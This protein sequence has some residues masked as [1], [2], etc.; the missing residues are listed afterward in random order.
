MKSKKV[1]EKMLALMLLMTLLLSYFQ[2]FVSA[3][4]LLDSAS[5]TPIELVN[6]PDVLQAEVNYELG[7]EEILW[8]L[9]FDKTAIDHRRQLVMAIDIAAPTGQGTVEQIRGSNEEEFLFDALT[10]EWLLSDYD[11]TGVKELTFK[12]PYDPAV[13]GMMNVLFKFRVLEERVTTVAANEEVLAVAEIDETGADAEEVA[14]TTE[15]IMAVPTETI[16]VVELLKQEHELQIEIPELEI[17]E[18][19]PESPESTE[20]TDPIEIPNGEDTSADSGKAAAKAA[21]ASVQAAALPAAAPTS[22]GQVFP[23][24]I[25]DAV[26]LIIAP[27]AFSTLTVTSRA[28]ANGQANIYSKNG[29]QRGTI[30]TVTEAQTNVYSMFAP[31]STSQALVY[32]NLYNQINASPNGS[33]LTDGAGN[34]EVISIDYSIVGFVNIGTSAAPILKPIAARVT[35]ENII[36]G[37]STSNHQN[38]ECHPIIEISNNLYSGMFYE[39]VKKMDITFEFYDPST[40]EAIN[41]AAGTPTAADGALLTFASL[42]AYTNRTTYPATGTIQRHEFAGSITGVPGILSANSLLSGPRGT[43]SGVDDD[44]YWANKAVENEDF[45]DILG[46]ADFNRAAVSFPITGTLHK[47]KFGSTWGRAWNTFASSA[48]IPTMHTPP[49]KTVQHLNSVVD[50]AASGFGHRYHNDLDR[51]YDGG[52]TWDLPSNYRVP[53]HDA[54]DPISLAANVLEKAD[55]YVETGDEYY[56][57]INQKT[58]NLVSEGLVQPTGYQ[59]EDTLPAGV[60]LSDSTWRNSIVLYDLN[61]SAI[62]DP[63]TTDS[64][65]NAATNQLILKLKPAVVNTI[66]TQSTTNYGGDF[67]IRI[68]VKVTNTT[69]DTINDLMENQAKTTF[70]YNDNVSYDQLSNKVHTKIKIPTLSIPVRKIWNDLDNHWGLREAITIQLQSSTDNVN[71]NDVTGQAVTIPADAAGTGLSSVFTDLPLYTIVNGIKTI[72]YYR[73][74]ETPA[75][76]A[77]GTPSY[78]PVS[79]KADAVTEQT[80]LTVTNSLLTTTLAF[81]KVLA[82][83]PL[84]GAEFTLY[85]SDGTTIIEG[86]ITSQANGTVSFTTQVPIGTYVIKETKT[87]TGLKTI[88][89]ITV[90]VSKNTTG[91]LVVAGFTNSEVANVPKD[92]DLTLTKVDKETNQPLVGMTFTITGPAFTQA[93]DFETDAS[94]MITIPNLIPGTYRIEETVAKD[95]YFKITSVFEFTINANGTVTQS[96]TNDTDAWTDFSYELK[97]EGNNQIKLT[98]KNT[99]KSILPVTGGPGFDQYLRNGLLALFGA[100]LFGMYLFKRTHKAKEA[101]GYEDSE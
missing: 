14:E 46:S 89:P 77:Y 25:S 85:K 70:L 87:P 93:T 50:G 21:P 79:I 91:N 51:Y 58:I 7:E 53:G 27:D 52:G 72:L 62:T 35:L 54:D 92:F 18:P 99:P 98:A 97:D 71:W 75:L 37:A 13:P 60:V 86:P 74:V 78:T 63:F 84:A 69:T 94:G 61:G 95:E 47:F 5:T 20:P 3:Q 57:Y 68:K 100:C 33:L 15:A 49:T 66:N 26:S 31:G 83:S 43:L 88:D 67:S 48:P 6:V 73:I 45:I 81:T 1:I 4:G 76:A 34:S 11:E 64:S 41:F 2:S 32:G 38:G 8:T 42:N 16:E 28:Q 44:T 65:Y 59:I 12:T 23:T 56:Y 82:G 36:I 80:E 39:F 96:A 22:A 40:N 29:S 9:A 30:T 55:R 17:P 90:T 101:I 19:E 10:E 24:A